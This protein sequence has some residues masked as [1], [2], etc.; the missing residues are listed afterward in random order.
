MNR[1]S[2]IPAKLT[3]KP[4]VSE[5]LVAK[6]LW[7]SSPI[8]FDLTREAWH[9]VLSSMG[10]QSRVAR[11]LLRIRARAVSAERVAPV[12][13]GDKVSALISSGM[14]TLLAQVMGRRSRLPAPA[15]QPAKSGLAGAAL[16]P[17]VYSLLWVNLQMCSLTSGFTL[18]HFR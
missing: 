10:N 1:G 15:P 6:T 17:P 5:F 4:W 7:I 2:G 3:E 9:R 18:S 13:V 8:K 16:S 11:L 12:M 14:F